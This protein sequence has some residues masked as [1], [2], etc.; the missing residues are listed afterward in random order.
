[1]NNRRFYPNDFPSYYNIAGNLK[2]SL[3]LV[4]GVGMVCSQYNNKLGLW[5]HICQIVI[6]IVD[7][8]YLL[9]T[10]SSKLRNK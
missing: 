7:P 8:A 10:R 1:M 9:M 3:S 6:V 4:M 2:H 5:T